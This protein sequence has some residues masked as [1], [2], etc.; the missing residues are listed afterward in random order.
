MIKI[1]IN[2][3]NI[4]NY[5]AKLLSR[6]IYPSKVFIE[7]YGNSKHF[8]PIISN[9]LNVTFKKIM[10]EVEF[11][12]TEN[13]ILENK[14]NFIKELT[15]SS[16]KFK[17]IVNNF[18]GK[19]VNSNIQDKV[20]NYE[21]IQFELNVLEEGEKIA[22]ELNNQ[23]SKT[24]NV[25]GN[26]EAPVRL[27]ITPTIALIDVTIKGLGGDIKINNLTA[28]KTIVVEDGLVLEEGKNKFK[29]YDSWV[30]VPYLVPGNNN[31]T[32]D[33]ATVNVKIKYNPRWI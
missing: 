30:D 23:L 3:K 6:V 17:N 32:L 18:N 9:D 33:K 31:I 13:E 16:I 5:N 14:S 25:S 24:I 8:N 29:D 21:V 19:L 20:R 27:E 11:K 10:I 12:G 1:F 15:I 26:L 2:N 22:E 4:K 28:N 7:S